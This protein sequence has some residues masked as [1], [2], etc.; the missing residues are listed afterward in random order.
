MAGP[1][2]VSELRAPWLGL[3][4]VAG[5]LDVLR[6]EAP[7]DQRRVPAARSLAGP[8]RSCGVKSLVRIP[9]RAI[10][11]IDGARCRTAAPIN[12][13][14]AS[15]LRTT[16][17]ARSRSPG[18]SAPSLA[19]HDSRSLRHR[20]H[21]AAAHLFLPLASPPLPLLLSH[22]LLPHPG[23][24]ATGDF[25][26]LTESR[27]LRLPRRPVVLSRSPCLVA[28]RRDL[29]RRTPSPLVQRHRARCHPRAP[30]PALRRRRARV[31]L[32]TR[33]HSVPRGEVAAGG[34]SELRDHPP[35]RLHGP[36]R[37]PGP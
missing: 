8:R 11:D 32:T 17:R 9:V 20:R 35:S 2:S 23:P 4:R 1:S 14:P 19:A 21:A 29:L 33:H 36:P 24:H 31:R 16:A 25:D 15:P 34:L 28:L 6:L 22:R 18:T 12:R 30:Q 26:L 37:R 7:R 27:G 5:T 3:S 13:T 10:D